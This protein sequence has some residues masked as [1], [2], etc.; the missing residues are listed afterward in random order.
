MRKVL[1]NKVRC[2]KC[3]DIIESKHRHDFTLCKCK[4]IFIDG[5]IDFQRY[6]WGLD[7]PGEELPLDEYI[8]FSYSVYEKEEYK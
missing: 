1:V 4:A 3:R 5:G 2:K 6:G 8:D 7:R